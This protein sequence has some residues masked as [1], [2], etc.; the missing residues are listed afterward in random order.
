MNWPRSL[1]GRLSLWLGLGLTLL[2]AVAAATTAER[3]R[4]E[5]DLILDGTLEEAA[6]RLL[7]LAVH[8]IIDR[9]S[10]DEAVQSIA[11]LREH[12][13]YFLYLVRDETGKVLLRSRKADP[14][15]FPPFAGIGFSDTP[16]HRIYA[17]S[18]LNGTITIA[19]AEPLAHRRDMARTLLWVLAL[20]LGLV[21]PVSLLGVWGAVRLSMRPLRRFRDGIEA[22][23]AGDLTPIPTGNLPSE[24]Q[25]GAHAVNRLLQR[26]RRTLEAE[27]SF[28]A[29]AAHE[30]RT[31]VAAALA[32]T[33][34]LIAETGD[35]T[36]DGA[37]RERARK[38][39]T[40][41][42]RLS[43]LSEKLMQLA[44][45]EGGLLQA[46]QPTDL[47]VILRMLAR[48]MGGSGAGRI[49]LALPPGAVASRID[50]DAFA[51]LA[52]NLIENAL[53]HGPPQQPVRVTLS[54]DGLLSVA[55]GGPALPAEVLARLGQP[56]QRGRSQA[57]GTGLG[58]AIARAIANGTGGRLELFSPIPGQKEGFEVRFLAATPLA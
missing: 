34:R 38:I 9:D 46:E 35:E 50:P 55:N 44:R 32:Q 17:D 28:T 6:Q 20:P 24:I 18:A 26:L 31:P 21:L 16:T 8:D 13:D 57:E 52:R 12:Q 33:Q 51:I 30:L 11:A 54:A 15:L 47:A 25:P 58:L 5:M 23:G 36:G 40:A 2:W 37:S 10:D 27:R 45:A 43:R 22:R 14:A 1:Q 49:A 41:L 7:P 19:V 53:R 4:Q 42:R 56:F 3:L 48:D 29:N 39:E